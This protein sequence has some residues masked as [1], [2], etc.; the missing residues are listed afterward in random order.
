MNIFVLSFWTW[1]VD[2]HWIG[3]RIVLRDSDYI[4]MPRDPAGRQP[5]AADDFHLH[6][7]VLHLHELESELELL[8]IMHSTLML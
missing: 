3:V 8:L 5:A 1:I 6:A 2:L 4:A 7:N